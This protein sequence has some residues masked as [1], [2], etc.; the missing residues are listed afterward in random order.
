M[1]GSRIFNACIALDL[2]IKLFADLADTV[3][4]CLSKGLGAP[5]GT[6]LATNNEISS[7]IRRN[8]KMLGG[9]MRQIGIIAAA[10]L[11]ALNHHVV[12]L[13]E[14]HRRAATLA[15]SLHK[16]PAKC[17]LKVTQATNMVFITPQPEDHPKLHQFLKSQ[18][19]LIG[20]K[21]PTMRMVTHLDISNADI[22]ATSNAIF[23]FYGEA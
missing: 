15:D 16:L 11:Y 22:T 1:D 14:D 2:D 18:K 17:Q 8:R 13:S 6:L 19:I 4:V 5:A 12:R 21:R 10:G 3:S 23:K 20:N 7:R 9:G